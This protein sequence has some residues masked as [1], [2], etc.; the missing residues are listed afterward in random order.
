M[1]VP[2][3]LMLVDIMV[4][5]K[6]FIRVDPILSSILLLCYS[7]SVRYNENPNLL[8]YVQE[9]FEIWVPNF[10]EGYSQNPVVQKQM[11]YKFLYFKC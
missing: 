10:P 1:I 11:Q 4:V 6:V 9:L 8:R 2:N 3:V 7:R 5:P